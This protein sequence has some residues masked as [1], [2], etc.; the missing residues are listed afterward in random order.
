MS[1]NSWKRLISG[2]FLAGA[3]LLSPVL[4]NAQEAPQYNPCCE[5][6]SCCNSWSL[7]DLL[8]PSD[9]CY[10]DFISPMTNPVFFEDPR[11][12]TEARLIYLNTR[13]QVLSVAAMSIWSRYNCEHV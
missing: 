9:E 8:L 7:G 12:L 4:A 13:F 2:M 6:N 5:C 10:K 11:M 1:L 3:T